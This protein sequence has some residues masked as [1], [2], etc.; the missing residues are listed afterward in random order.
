MTIQER[1]HRFHQAHLGHDVLR[2]ANVWDAASAKIIE[3]AGAEAVATTSAGV[4]W[5]LGAADGDDLDRDTAVA[6]ISRICAAVSVPVTADIETGYGD[7]PDDVAETIRRVIEAGAVGVNL[8]DGFGD[9]LRDQSEQVDRIVAARSGADEAG[10]DL[11]LNARVDTYLRGIGEPERRWELTVARA[12]EYLSAGA[13]GIFVPGLD[14][15]IEVKRLAHAIDGPLNIMVGPG[16]P[17][18]SELAAAGVRRV[19]TGPAIPQAAY[20]LADRAARDLF[21]DAGYGAVGDG[22]DFGRLNALWTN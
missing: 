6:A 10:L 1:A 3:A 18:I 7:T 8:E 22:W 13:S 11:Y 12:A 15:P 16:S 17:L 2:L 19:S 14:D 20:A 9:G 4:A 21:A 5:S